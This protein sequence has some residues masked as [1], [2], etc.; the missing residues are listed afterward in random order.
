M[1]FPRIRLTFG[2]FQ[3]L[4]I[5]GFL[6]TGSLLCHSALAIQ[7]HEAEQLKFDSSLTLA[8]LLD[9]TLERHPQSGLLAARSASAQANE[10]YASRWLPDVTRLNAFHLSDNVFDDTGLYENEVALSFPIWLPGEKKA[11]TVMGERMT[12]S[13][14]SDQAELRWQ[15]SGQ[16][17]QQLWQLT[18]AVRQ[19]ELSLEQE[20]R[21]GELMTQVTLFAEAGELSRADQL[22]VMEEFAVLK[23]ETMLLE[24]GYMD[25]IRS[26]HSLTGLE[27]VPEQIDEQLSEIHEINDQHPA[28]R[29]AM[30]HVSESSASTEV[31]REGTNIRPSVDVFWRGLRSDA[32]SPGLNALGIGFAMP[33]GKSPKNGPEVAK[34]FEAYATAQAELV[35]IKRELELQLHEANH[36]LHTSREQ[37]ENSDAI[38]NAANERFELDKLAYELGEFSTSEWLRR[39]SRLKDMERSHELLLIQQGAAIAAYNQAV[40]ESL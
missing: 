17:R 2:V 9:L 29:Q 22:A 23:G 20:Q 6:L 19:W 14:D 18:L 24:A 11:Q 26:Y 8:S 40:G 25:A 7:E 27:V 28:L 35:S 33:L 39:L 16:L 15:V 31:A 1:N 30:D 32:Q 38:M 21:M 10:K 34:A 37:I 12:A 13:Q 36:T 5:P 3:N 4:L